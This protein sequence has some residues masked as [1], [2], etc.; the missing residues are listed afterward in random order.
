VGKF[1]ELSLP[2]GLL[3]PGTRYDARGRWYDANLVRWRERAMLAIGGW[4][5]LERTAAVAV[6]AY[7]SDDG[8]VMTTDTTDANDAGADDFVLVP[9]SPAINDAAYFGYSFRFTEVEVE[10]GTAGTGNTVVWEYYNG[11]AWTALSGVTDSTNSF[12]TAGLK[13][14]VWTLPWDWAKTNINAAGS[15]YWVRARVTVAGSTTATGTQAWI[16]TG[17]VDVDEA[18]RGMLAWRNNAQSPHLALGT[19]TSLYVFTTGTLTNITPVGFTAGNSNATLSTGNYGA[20]SYG[21]GPYGTGD[22]AQATLTEANTWQIDNYGEDLVACAYS[23]GDIHY[24]D[25]SAAGVAAQLTNSPSNCVGV[26]V[27]PE[28]FVVALGAGA[29]ARNVAW[30][31][32]DDITIWTA[33]S[34]NQA[35]DYILRTP[36]QIMCGRRFTNE[37]LIWTDV[38]LWAMRFIGGDFVY[39]FA[40]RGSNCGVISRRAVAIGNGRAL[41]M[42]HKGFFMYNGQVVPMQCDVGDY[43]FGD[44][45]RVQASKIHAVRLSEVGETWWFYPSGG[46]TECDRYV[47]VT[48]E[49]HWQAG[50]LQRTAMAG[51]DAF[52]FP[53]GADAGG[54]I[55]QHETGTSY[56]DH[57]GTTLTPYAESGPIQIAEGDN[58]MTILGFIPD[59]RTLG[60]ASMTVYATLFP[61]QAETTH[62]PYTLANP[63]D[64]RVTGRQVRIKVSQVRSGWRFGTPRAEVALGGRR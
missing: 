42:S 63:T 31:D 18:V 44:M 39:S 56:K 22:T 37:T 9:A 27:T 36:G 58:V 26:V 60:D 50:I 57:N 40:E 64:A 13:S 49:G 11:S 45:N 2:P 43:V 38:D 51:R 1:V 16:G 25:L 55:Y 19:P 62:G 29:N 46:A 14:V 3:K 20:G 59:E 48:D 32:Q 23:D 53:I 7:V 30:S 28:G 15:M 12:T 54:V 61:T 4:Q 6:T 35:G 41:W 47:V 8:G 21:A 5:P 52:G 24:W 34:T 10:V 17:P 33:A